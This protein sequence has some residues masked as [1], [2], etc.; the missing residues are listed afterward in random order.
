[1]QPFEFSTFTASV[2]ALLTPIIATAVAYIAYQQ[3]RTN[4]R[5]EERESRS[6]RLAVYRRVK[7]LL[8]D[9]D[10]TREVRKDLYSDFC[11]ASAEADFLFPEILREWLGEIE[12]AGVQWLDYNEAISLAAPDAD[13]ASITRIERDMDRLI[14]SLQ[15]AHCVLREKFEEHMK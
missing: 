11:E 9:V 10:N 8:R 2:S 7:A 3:W 4:H 14:D 15:N 12:S 13:Q 6:S 5:R 1:M